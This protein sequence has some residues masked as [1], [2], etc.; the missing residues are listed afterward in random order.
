MACTRI[1]IG[2]GDCGSSWGKG[3]PVIVPDVEKFQ[4]HIACNT[5]SRSEIVIP[6]LQDDNVV[7]VL[8]VDSDKLNDFDEIDKK[9]LEA[10][11]FIILKSEQL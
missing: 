6:A 3:E 8:D 1:S 11:I 9:Y 4:G 2:K 10:L 5:A 7:F